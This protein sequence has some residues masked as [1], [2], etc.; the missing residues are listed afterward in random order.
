M[1]NFTDFVDW[2][3][4]TLDAIRRNDHVQWFLKPHP[5]EIWYGGQTMADLVKREPAHI[6]MLPHKIDTLS[7]MSAA[8]T[9][10]TIHGTA[11][12]EAVA[13]GIP[14]ISA[15]RSYFSDW[16]FA[17]CAASAMQYG[18]LLAQVGSLPRPDERRRDLA[19]ACLVGAYGEPHDWAS[20]LR[21]PCDS[22]GHQLFDQVKAMV[23]QQGHDLEREVSRI[24]AFLRQKDFDSFSA[25]A[26]VRA[27]EMSVGVRQQ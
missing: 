25:W 2:F 6:R 22:L 27:A 23:R 8:D 5:M 9:V 20:A 14:V 3:R 18:E 26:F 16:G 12:M 17:H 1:K 24:D 21:V 10:V 7:V 4:Q 11:A 15:D 19:A 13:I